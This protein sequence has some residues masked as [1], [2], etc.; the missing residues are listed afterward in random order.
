MTIDGTEYAGNTATVTV[1][2]PELNIV[3]TGKMVAKNTLEYTL[4]IS[5]TADSK[6]D[7]FDLVITD[8]V[9]STEPQIL[10][11]FKSANK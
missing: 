4:T 1:V 2:E 5:H 11:Y 9:L 6:T 8:D 3:K 10:S 7:A